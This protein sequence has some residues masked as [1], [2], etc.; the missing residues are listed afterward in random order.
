MAFLNWNA[1]N[2]TSGT[3]E[4]ALLD[5]LVANN[6]DVAVVTEAEVRLTE[7]RSTWP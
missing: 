2:L 7:E 6:V 4:L 1:E 3:K 5:L